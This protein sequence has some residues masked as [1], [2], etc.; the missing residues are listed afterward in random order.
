[1]PS[2]C[3]KVRYS[4]H[5][6][7]AIRGWCQGLSGPTLGVQGT[8]VLIVLASEKPDKDIRSILAIFCFDDYINSSLPFINEL[9]GLYMTWLEIHK[10]NFLSTG[11]IF[12]NSYRIPMTFVRLLLSN[13]YKASLRG[14]Y[15]QLIPK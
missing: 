11:M 10:T 6:I 15:I 3:R 7:C 4:T 9:T 8:F 2:L 1:M 14:L 5:R 13:S 12:D